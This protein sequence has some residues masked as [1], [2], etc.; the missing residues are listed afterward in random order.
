MALNPAWIVRKK[1][2][3]AWAKKNGVRVPAGI[4]YTPTCGSACR[5]LIRRIQI[6]AG[7]THRDG[8][9]RE[10][11]RKLVAPKPTLQERTLDY[12][13][14][15][16]GVVESPPGSNSGERVREY[17]NA[18]SLSGTTGWPWCAAFTAWCSERA[19][20]PLG[21]DWNTAYVP[22]Y[23]RAA[24][25]RKHGLRVVAAS[26][27]IPGDFVCFDWGK[28]GV[29]DHIGVLATKVTPNGSFS[30]V[31]GNTSYGDNSNGGKVMLRERSASQVQAFI[32]VV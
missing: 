11:V 2:M 24:K 5:D 3:V 13:R 17:Q 23:V 4:R 8:K 1:R 25:D 16:I 9:W 27:A 28:D 10:D 19:G 31:E 21:K 15:E 26:D 12:A 30:S 7:L 14:G 22:S 18:S 32:R 20:R 6:K 29:A